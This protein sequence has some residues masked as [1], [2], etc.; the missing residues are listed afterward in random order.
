MSQLRVLHHS[1]YQTQCGIAMYAEDL[2]NALTAAGVQNKMC[3]VDTAK[4]AHMTDSQMRVH[5]KSVCEEAKQHDVLH[6]HHDYSFFA[7]GPYT[8]KNSNRNFCSLLSQLD[9]ANVPTVV[10]FHVNAHGMDYWTQ[11]RRRHARR[12]MSSNFQRRSS[13][14]IKGWRIPQRM[15]TS[16]DR[17]RAVTFSP[18]PQ[19]SHILAGLDPSVMRMI[20]LAAPK[21]TSHFAGMDTQTAKEKLGLPRHSILLSQ[22]GFV[23]AYKGFEWALR[24]I[25]MLPEN[26]HFAVVGG[27]HRDVPSEPTLNR[28]LEIW[29]GRNPDRLRVTGFVN[30][31]ERDLYLAATDIFLAPYTWNE[32]TASGAVTWALTSGK[33]V[34]ASTIDCFREINSVYDC[35][36]TVPPGM[37][38]ELAWQIQRVMSSTKLR[39]QLVTNAARFAHDHS[40]EVIASK[41]AKE[42][43]EL[44]ASRGV[45]ADGA[46]NTLPLSRAA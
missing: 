33:P 14:Y 35:M 17:F 9:K 32:L 37:I 2:M 44:A 25:E 15:R 40:W 43:S 20:P 21:P 11:G 29:T 39:Q 36:L 19:A 13:L 27:R 23:S 12:V 6:I 26:Y 46:P 22:F 38:H 24:G 16:P 41:Y 5:L 31:E 34:I 45:V 7:N 8:L 4:L 42:F 1:T 3:P 18:R 10:T 28:I 30:D